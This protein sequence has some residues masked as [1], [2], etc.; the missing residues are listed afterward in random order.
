MVIA[1]TMQFT[2]GFS[3]LAASWGRAP[4]VF[5]PGAVD[6]SPVDTHMAAIERLVRGMDESVLRV[7]LPGQGPQSG[8]P[9][10]VALRDV[11]DIAD[12][13]AQPGV[14]HLQAN[15]VQLY[16]SS[17]AEV[18]RRFRA[19]VEADV[20]EVRDPSTRV[21]LGLFVSSGGA[22]APYH[23]DTE[24]NVLVQI[25]GNKKMHMFPPDEQTFPSA[26]RESRSEPV[27]AG[28]L[29]GGV[30][31]ASSGRGTGARH[32]AVPPTHEP[33]LGRY[34][35]QRPVIVTG[36]QLRHSQHRSPDVA[37]QGQSPPAAPG[38]RGTGRRHASDAGQRQS[39][40]RARGARVGPARA[41][42]S[43]TQRRCATLS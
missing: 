43:R 30:R 11:H 24:H 38:H 13:L 41:R 21:S 5:E 1:S 4:W 16:D 15:E 7:R 37:T 28:Q 25:H 29:S 17:W 31:A 39:R 42:L 9:Q 14:L 19:R 12:L 27:C 26:A 34:R 32:G 36:G 22:T 18:A 40:F 35:L 6:L 23:A 8:S 33:P 3:T 2:T 20:P 10:R